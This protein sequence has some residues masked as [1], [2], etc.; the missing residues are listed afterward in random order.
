MSPGA[1]ERAAAWLLPALV[2][3]VAP[4]ALRQPPWV[5]GIFALFAAWR[6]MAR[7]AG[8]PLPDRRHRALLIAKNVFAVLVFAA[9]LV[10]FGG[11]LGRDAGIALLIILTGLKLLELQR[12]RDVYMAAFL[13]YFLV[14]TNFLYTQSM[15]TAL[16]MLAVVVAVTA[17]LVTFSD[18]N[19]GMPA[20]ERLALAGRLLLQTLPVLLLAFVLFPRLPGPLWGLP[21]MGPDA[22]TGLSDEMSLGMISELSLSDELAFRADFGGAPPPPELLYWRGPVLWH[23]DGRTWT[24]GAP[25]SQAAAPVRGRR[26]VEYTVTLEPHGERWLLGL[27]LVA[28]VPAE[29]RLSS[30]YRL[31]RKNEVRRR[32]RYRLRSTLEYRVLEISAA[33]RERALQ[34][35]PAAHPRARELAARWRAGGLAGEALV[36]RA[37]TLFREQPFVYTLR[38]PRPFGDPVDDFLFES[39][40]GFC[41]HYAAAF[42]VLMRAAGLPARV[43]TGYQGGDY[44]PVGEFLTV[45]QRDAHAW[46]EVWLAGRGWT[47]VDPT[48]AVAPQRIE[49]GIE[50]ALPERSGALSRALAELPAAD[51]LL[52]GLQAL[53]GAAGNAW[54]QWV[55][56]YG[57]DRQVLL[58][59][60]LGFERVDGLRLGVTLS[61]ALSASFVALAVLLARGARAPARDP[62]RRH[63]DRFCAKLERVGLQRAPHEGPRDFA[64][65]AARQRPELAAPIAAITDRYVAVRYAGDAGAAAELAGAVRAF[66]PRR[67]HA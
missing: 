34:L 29:A 38:P 26:P 6:A 47:R 9:V 16:L 64:A 60:R 63:Y 62:A 43:V 49:M 46:A 37:L 17:A 36:E 56:G 32:I 12:E 11:R 19:A 25:F 42:T 48:A 31:L 24:A 15:P 4:H 3:V 27:D 58:L 61:A 13:G 45:R 55:L 65:R 52:R 7:V 8:W 39:R 51:R 14:V 40:R 67:R 22:V 35:P 57:T 10:N 2:L 18:R 54:T 23:D 44:N 50:Q 5:S 59:Q 53:W 28:R 21:Q 1:A 20:R 66:S 30:D 41:E 33:E